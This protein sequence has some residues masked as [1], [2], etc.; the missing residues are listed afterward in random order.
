MNPLIATFSV[1]ARDPANGDLGVA[2]ASKFLAVGSVVP[3][4]AAGAGAI[5]T[6]SYANLSFGPDGLAL[7]AEGLDAQSALDRLLAADEGR[8]QRQVGIVDRQGGAATWTGAACHG[9]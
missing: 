9:W 7:L 1:V 5:A 3:W 8:E 4:V 6:Q 2:V